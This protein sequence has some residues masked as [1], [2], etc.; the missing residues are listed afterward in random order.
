MKHF[1]KL[2]SIF[3]LL[4]MLV[5]ISQPGDGG[6]TLSDTNQPPRETNIDINE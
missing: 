1:K 4:G 3:L 2:L 5:G 6:S